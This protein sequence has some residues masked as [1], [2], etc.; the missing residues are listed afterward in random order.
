MDL[1]VVVP[2][3]NEVGNVEALLSDVLAACDGLGRSYEV[4]CVND[5]STDG[6]DQKLDAAAAKRA[7]I[8]VVHFARNYGQTPAMAAGFQA[9]VGDVILMMDGDR[10][11]DPA[12][13]PR[14]L[15]KLEE[16]YDLVSGWR[17]NRQ[18]SG[19]QKIPSRIANRLIRRITGVQLHDTGCSLKAY[20]RG[21]LDPTELFGEMHRFLPV[22][23]AMNGGRIT[24]L[25]VNHRPRM[26]GASKYG[27]NR[28]FRVLADLLL[29][30]LLQRYTTRPLH[31][32]AKVAQWIFGFAALM[33][34]IAVVQGLWPG[35]HGLLD[36]PF[37]SAVVAMLGGMGFLGLGVIA[38]YT[39]RNRYIPGG[40]HPWC[41]LRTVNFDR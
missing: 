3:Y 18:D 4:I 29:I 7:Q 11:N 14:L 28:T 13:F 37:L 19:I 5:G 39:V 1:S 20:R 2:M 15:A 31:F 35:G 32:F 21:V 17:K 8:R 24:E 27:I 10:Q 9:A 38:E 40:R 33:V 41:V 22:Y 30:H 16:G 12:D 36:V 25:V 6:T 23:V 34:G 26:A